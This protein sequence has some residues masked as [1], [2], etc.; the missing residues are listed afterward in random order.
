[1]SNPRAPRVSIE[2]PV[3]NGEEFLSSAIASILAQTYP[4]F[5]LI[6]SD[7]ASTDRTETICREYAASDRRIRYYRNDRNLGAA[8]NFNRPSSWRRESTLS[9]PLTSCGPGQGAECSRYAA[10][11][12]PTARKDAFAPRRAGGAED[13]CRLMRTRAR[14]TAV[15]P[16]RKTWR[17]SN[18]R[19]V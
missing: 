17:R 16:A 4:D 1:M 18:R 6:I 7:N 12:S 9:G 13:A 11:S 2:L 14:D 10:L 19:F 8:V 15:L 3:F 5:E